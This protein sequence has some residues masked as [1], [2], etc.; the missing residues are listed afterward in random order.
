[1]KRI[2][3]HS[4]LLISV[5]FLGCEKEELPIQ[6]HDAGDVTTQ[7][8]ETGN[9]YRYQMFYDLVTD[10]TVAQN[11]KIDWDLGFEAKESGWHII[12]NSSKGGAIAATGSTDFASVTSTTGT[13]W[14]VD[15]PAGYDDSTAIGDY[16]GTG[17][18]YLVDRG[19]NHAGG[20][21]GYRKMMILSQTDSDYTIRY[22]KLDGSQD[23]TVTVVKDSTVNYNAWSISTHEQL[24]IE[25]PKTEWDLYFGQY[26]H[27]FHD[28]PS[29]YLVHGVLL[30]R[31]KVEVA[32]DFTKSFDEI[33][34]ADVAGYTFSK[35]LDGIGYNWKVYDYDSGFYILYPEKN[36]IIK[37]TEG[38]YFKLHFID[39]YNT[40]GH[41][42]APKFEVQE[43]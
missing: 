42:G 21:T 23:T 25:P 12:L 16:R 24:N 33:T 5:V 3:L 10:Q 32:Q 6:P 18:V 34:Y 22:A 7:Q 8:M 36:Y 38:R 11:M 15:H 31:Y 39:F 9:D 41:K 4:C 14:E 37:S 28:P 27:I 43:L 13:V 19:Y 35:H 40:Q 30:N 29:S 20:H 17:E 1:M 2:V 26:T